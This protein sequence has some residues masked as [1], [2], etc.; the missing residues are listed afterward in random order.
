MKLL[1]PILAIACAAACM[2]AQAAIRIC[3]FTGRPFDTETRTYVDVPGT[4]NYVSPSDRLDY[5]SVN[6]DEDCDDDYGYEEPRRS[7]YSSSSS[8]SNDSWDDDLYGPRVY[9]GYNEYLGY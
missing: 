3:P 7:T 9:Q 4:S 5:P 8:S 2:P 1:G 6:D